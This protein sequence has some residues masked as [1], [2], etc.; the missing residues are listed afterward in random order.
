MELLVVLTVT[1]AAVTAGVPALTSIMHSSGLS[2]ASNLFFSH[3]QLTRSE[4]I[5]RNGRVVMCKSADG[6]ACTSSGGWEQGWIVFHDENDNGLF[7]A[8][9]VLIQRMDSLPVGWRIAG[10]QNV[11]RYI[12]YSPTGETKL[13]SGAFQAGTV[14]VCNLSNG[15]KEAR[16]IVINA[17]G[18]PRVQKTTVSTCV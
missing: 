17:V 9:E 14:T 7:D 1:A 5:K 11:A 13:T 4:A 18:R 8:A 6:A 10:N 16:K 3:L 15:H 2:S 12:S